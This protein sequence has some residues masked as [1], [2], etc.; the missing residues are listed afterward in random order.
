MM[1]QF[2]YN[3]FGATG[4]NYAVAYRDFDDMG[5]TGVVLDEWKWK[6]K[7]M[8]SEALHHLNKKPA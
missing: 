1:T 4:F 7:V 6:L 2:V 5:F 3:A 8:E